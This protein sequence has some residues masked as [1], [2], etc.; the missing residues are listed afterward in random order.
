MKLSIDD[1]VIFVKVIKEGSIVKASEK[2]SIPS[3]TISR[4]LTQLEKAIGGLL[5]YRSHRKIMLTAL[6]Q[7]YITKFTNLVEEFIETA[8]NLED[9]YKKLSGTI[10]ITAPISL[11]HQWFGKC[12]FSFMRQ[13]PDIKIDLI[14]TNKIIDLADMNIDIAIRVGDLKDS[15]WIAKKILLSKN[16]LCSSKDY[17]N[18]IHNCVNPADLLDKNLLNITQNLSWSLTNTNLHEYYE[19][20]ANPYLIMDDTDLIIDAAKEGMG[21]CFVPSEFVKES[22]SN[23][24]LVQILPDWV[25]N[26]RPISL[27]FKDRTYLPNRVRFFKEYIENYVSLNK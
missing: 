13:Y 4:R 9:Y 14:A 12:I 3:P 27:I 11:T 5:M 17:L 19:V 10:R 1:L 24:E 25:G 20:R 21:I 7:M 22:I 15:D 6:G 16:I 8:E 2:L 26:P 18:Q 23:G